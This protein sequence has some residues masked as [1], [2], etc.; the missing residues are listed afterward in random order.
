MGWPQ[1]LGLRLNGKLLQPV[2]PAMPD[3]KFRCI[4]AGPHTVA[5]SF[6]RELW[7]PEGL[8]QPLQS[9]NFKLDHDHNLRLI[10]IRFQLTI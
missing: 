5:V 1:Q 2:S 3:L 10:A 7:E 9:Q 4:D 6:F 8:P